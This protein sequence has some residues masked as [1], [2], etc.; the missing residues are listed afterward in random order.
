MGQE[1]PEAIQGTLS[2]GSGGV[3]VGISLSDLLDNVQDW[4]LFGLGV[5]ILVVRL[6]HDVYRF[7]R[8]IK[9]SR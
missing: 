7:R 8:D 3:A 9:K 6:L 5:A 1:I 4:T 2:Y